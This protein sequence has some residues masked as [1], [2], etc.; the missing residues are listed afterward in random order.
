MILCGLFGYI[1]VEKLIVR[2]A[3]GGPPKMKNKVHSPGASSAIKTPL[4][5]VTEKTMES[6]VRG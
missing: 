5:E 6:V 1:A 2:L 4:A 3:G